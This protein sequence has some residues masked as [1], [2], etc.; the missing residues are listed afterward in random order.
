MDVVEPPGIL[1]K[2]KKRLEMEL[3]LE[4]KL[5]HA[6][7][8]AAV[9]NTL[10]LPVEATPRTQQSDLKRNNWKVDCAVQ[11]RDQKIQK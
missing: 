10:S 7:Y 9:I 2:T 1:V 6:S 4:K 11:S 8:A 3:A 5:E